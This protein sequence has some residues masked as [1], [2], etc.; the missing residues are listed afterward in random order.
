MV[1]LTSRG[2]GGLVDVWLLQLPAQAIGGFPNT[3]KNVREAALEIKMG[4]RERVCVGDRER[5]WS[6][7][8]DLLRIQT[9]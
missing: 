1:S 3:E 4:E 2:G 6:E 5:D 8:F 9:T 7:S